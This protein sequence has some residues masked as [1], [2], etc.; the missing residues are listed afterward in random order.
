MPTALV[1]SYYSKGRELMSSFSEAEYNYRMSRL[2]FAGVCAVYFF[3]G[4]LEWWSKVDSFFYRPVS[5]FQLFG[6]KLNDYFS[7]SFLYGIKMINVALFAAFAFKYR[8]PILS[9]LLFFFTF[10]VAGFPNNFY[11]TD[12]VSSVIMIFTA[13][14]VVSDWALSLNVNKNTVSLW[15]LQAARVFT[16]LMYLVIG[17]AQLR[18]V[19][20]SWFTSDNLEVLLL[21]AG[22][23]WGQELTR[24]PVLLNIAAFFILLLNVSSPLALFLRGKLS[25]IYPILWIA[26]HTLAY[27]SVNLTMPLLG[28]G[29]LFFI[30]WF[31]LFHGFQEPS[32]IKPPEF[33]HHP[34]LKFITI[35]LAALIW[36]SSLTQ[37]AIWPILPF[38]LYNRNVAEDPY[39]KVELYSYYDQ[40]Q[41]KKLFRVWTH[42]FDRRHLNFFLSRRMEKSEDIKKKTLLHL[43]RLICKNMRLKNR[44]RTYFPL[45][46]VVSYLEKGRDIKT[47]DFESRVIAEQEIRCTKFRASITPPPPNVAPQP[48]TNSEGE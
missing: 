43:E 12:P 3:Y 31:A 15:F 5:V 11:I 1:K 27:F 17:V 45:T 8:S 32:E 4:E 30:P 6:A 24:F 40:D 47:K 7:Y 22:K 46:V 16:V 26:L 14:F 36:L 39:R 20:L 48:N 41:R 13:L 28:I 44:T 9:S 37:V 21:I 42:P 10:F 25:L 35:G 18:D 38:D 29:V 34:Q 23:S 2:L 33:D 19:G